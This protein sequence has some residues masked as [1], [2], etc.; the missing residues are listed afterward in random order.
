MSIS[1][2][3]IVEIGEYLKGK[4]LYVVARET[5]ISYPTLVKFFLPT[6]HNFTFGTIMLMTNYIA[7]KS[8]KA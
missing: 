6:P 8:K 7:S 1:V 2:L 4:Q 3:S 5:G